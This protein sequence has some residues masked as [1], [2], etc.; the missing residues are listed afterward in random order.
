MF[1][2]ACS[3]NE[4]L[5]LRNRRQSI[6]SFFILVGLLGKAF[7]PHIKD[8]SACCRKLRPI[9]DTCQLDGFILV[10]RS[11]CTDQLCSNQNEDILFTC[12]QRR[13]ISRGDIVCGDN[14]MMSRYLAVVDDLFYIRSM[15]DTEPEIAVAFLFLNPIGNLRL[16]SKAET[17]KMVGRGLRLHPDKR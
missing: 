17:P 11:R 14:R 13:K 2:L 5:P 8:G 9:A 3:Y 16:Y 15:G 10:C 6:I 1:A 12:R 7:P 4:G